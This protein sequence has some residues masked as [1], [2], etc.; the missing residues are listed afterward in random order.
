MQLEQ[1][2]RAVGLTGIQY[3]ALSIVG[4]REGI[5]SAELSRRFFVTQQS[6]IEVVAGLERRG[7]LRRSP[8]PQNRRILAAVLTDA[9]RAILAEADAIV[10][11]V[12]SAAFASVSERDFQEL[13][14]ILSGLLR[15]IRASQ[16]KTA[17]DQRTAL[18]SAGA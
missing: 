18:R 17:S 12:E 15:D 13:R 7:L 14:R 4:S 5:S 8:S 9:G 1:E 6:M 11:A 3:T 16:P 10:D 2:L